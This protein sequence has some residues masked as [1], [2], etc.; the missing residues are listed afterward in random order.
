MKQYM[1]PS[2]LLYDMY[3]YFVIG[4]R[5]PELEEEIRTGLIAKMERHCAHNRYTSIVNKRNAP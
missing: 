1:I 5:T 4:E 3:I 2:E